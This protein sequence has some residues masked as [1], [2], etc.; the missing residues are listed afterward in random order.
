MNTEVIIAIIGLIST[1]VSAFLG[2]LMSS[3]AIKTRIE[4][5]EKMVAKHNNLIERM[6]HVEGKLEELQSDIDEI[7]HKT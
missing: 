4:A 5:L 1:F 6:Y 3:N 7:K 2:A